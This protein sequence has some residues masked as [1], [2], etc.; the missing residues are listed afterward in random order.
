M[1]TTHRV[2]YVRPGSLRAHCVLPCCI[3]RRQSKATIAPRRVNACLLQFLQ[4][5]SHVRR[6]TLRTRNEITFAK[7]NLISQKVFAAI[8]KL[9]ITHRKVPPKSNFFPRDDQRLSVSEGSDVRF[10]LCCELVQTR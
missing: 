10:V 4:E 7:V 2:A 8:L 5:L 1:H 3:R 6:S 9:K